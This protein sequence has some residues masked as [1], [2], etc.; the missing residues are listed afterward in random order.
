MPRSK[1]LGVIAASTLIST[2]AIL[3]ISA[4]PAMASPNI[5]WD[6][7]CAN[8]AAETYS[9]IFIHVWA[10]NQNFTG[11]FEVQTPEH[12]Y[13]NSADKLNIAGGAGPTF[14]FPNGSQADY[15]NYCVTA[16]KKL[17]PGNY[18]DIAY[19]CFVA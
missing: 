4:A 16:W 6:D 12:T 11:H 5:C 9:Q 17:G 10:Y 3:G 19:E 18:Q 1:R 13:A 15:G 14:A 8:V 2:G 7:V